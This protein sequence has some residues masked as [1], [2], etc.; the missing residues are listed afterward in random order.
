MQRHSKLSGPLTS[1]EAERFLWH[2]CQHIDVFSRG[3]MTPTQGDLDA[4]YILRAAINQL[5][6]AA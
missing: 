3:N 5:Q 1:T 4:I 2:A 6:D